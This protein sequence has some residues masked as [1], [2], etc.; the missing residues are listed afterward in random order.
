MKL[1][2]LQDDYKKAGKLRLVGLLEGWEDIEEV[3]YHQGFS[4]VSKV[5]CTELISRHQN[6]PLGDYI[7]IKKI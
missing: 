7:D 6:N 1:L 3:L 4:Y 2:K 5:I